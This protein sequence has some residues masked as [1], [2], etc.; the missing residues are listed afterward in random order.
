MCTPGEVVVQSSLRRVQLFAAPRT[1]A[2]QTSLSFTICQSLFKLMSIESVIPS[3]HLILWHPLLLLPSVFPSIR[4]FSNELALTGNFTVC[5]DRHK[6]FRVV[7]EAEVD[8]FFFLK[9]PCF[10]Y[11]PT[12]DGNLI[13]SSSAFSK[14]SLYI[15]KFLV[16]LLLKPSLKDFEYYFASM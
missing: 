4:A 2:H 1:A 5:C 16:H 7:N 14:S 11:N 15:W 6:D 12:N 8:F 3:N 13:S 9:F 10:F